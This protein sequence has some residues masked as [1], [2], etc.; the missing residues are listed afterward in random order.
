MSTQYGTILNDRLGSTVTREVVLKS[1][2]L[3][4]VSSRRCNLRRL[5]ASLTATPT[6]F[7]GANFSELQLPERSLSDPKSFSRTNPSQC[8]MCR[9]ASAY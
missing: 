2:L 3:L 4:K 1:K 7:P 8:S 6:S 5:L 9:F